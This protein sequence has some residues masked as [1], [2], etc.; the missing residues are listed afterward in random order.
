ML[1]LLELSIGYSPK[2]D[3]YLLKKATP[4]N[5]LPYKGNIGLLSCLF[6]LPGS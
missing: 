6:F 4:K 3:Y 5:V 1:G 2:V